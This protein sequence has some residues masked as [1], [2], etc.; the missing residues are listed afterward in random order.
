MLEENVAMKTFNLSFCGSYGKEKLGNINEKDS[1][2]FFQS[3]EKHL[4]SISLKIIIIDCY[5]FW[6][7]LQF[8]VAFIVGWNTAKENSAKYNV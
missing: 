7:F 2:C 6:E 4:H 3:N 5:N 8:C 1:G